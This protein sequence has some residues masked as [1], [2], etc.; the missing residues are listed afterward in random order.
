MRPA[1]LLAC[2]VLAAGV[3]LWLTGTYPGGAR[4]IVR[5]EG[6]QGLALT[7]DEERAPLPGAPADTAAPRSQPEGR[8]VIEEPVAP[9]EAEPESAA[10]AGP[11]PLLV[12]RVLRAD[13]EPCARAAIVAATGWA[14]VLP[15][16]LEDLG[17]VGNWVQ[18]V[19]VET[20]ADGRFEVREGLHL[21]GELVLHVA[22]PGHAP[23]R[24]DRPPPGAR[25]SSAPVD[26][27]DLRLRSGAV[28]R[29]RVVDR[30]GGAIAGARLQLAVVL[31]EQGFSVDFPA[32]GV[33]LAASGADGTFALDQLSPGPFTLLVEAP[34]RASARATEVAGQRPVDGLTVVLDAGR[35]IAGRVTGL[36]TRRAAQGS[37]SAEGSNAPA[38][39]AV[40]AA[41]PGLAPLRVEA[42]PGKP[43]GERVEGLERA[44]G[45]ARVALVADD[46]AFVV[47]GL[48][49]GLPYTLVVAQLNSEGKG[50]SRAREVTPKEAAPGTAGVELVWDAQ[51]RATLRVVDGATGAPIE[52]CT[53][54]WRSGPPPR[55]GRGDNLQYL[56]DGPRVRSAF[57]GGL[58]PLEGLP[59]GKQDLELAVRITAVGYKTKLAERLTLRGQIE[60]DLGEVRLESAPTVTVKV[61][62]QGDGGPVAGAKVYLAR[63]DYQWLDWYAQ[64]GQEV[65]GDEDVQSAVTDADGLAVLASLPGQRAKLTAAS[66]RYV[67]PEAK[68]HLLSAQGGD[69]LTVEVG[70]GGTLL[71]R[72]RRP[73]GA[74]AVGVKVICRK[75]ELG[76]RR[77]QART[78]E[79][80]TDETGTAR[81]LRLPAG[82]HE[83][84]VSTEQQAQRGQAAWR[85]GLVAVGGEVTVVL[86]TPASGTL[87]GLVLEAGQPLA[88]AS[89]TIG[90]EAESGGGED[91]GGFWGDDGRSGRQATSRADGSYTLGPIEAGEWWVTVRHESRAM[92]TRVPVRIVEGQNTLDVRLDVALL[93]GRVIDERDE[94]LAQLEA[95]VFAEK[96]NLQGGSQR[97]A[98]TE[99]PTGEVDSDWNWISLDQTRTD[100]EGAFR[101]RGLTTARP[102]K[103][104]V[105]GPYIE[106]LLLDLSDFAD[107]ELRDLGALRA[108]PAGVLRV[109]SAGGGNDRLRVRLVTASDDPAEDG[110][111]VRK[112]ADLRGSNGPRWSSVPLGRYRVEVVDSNG[113]PTGQR[114]EVEVR[115]RETA[116]VEV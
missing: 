12:G 110:R 58:V 116:T 8:A 38:D 21:G 29:G 63:A 74:P 85:P 71:A 39:G 19:R 59:A 83:A 11:P 45:G 23:L 88:R 60:T 3:L 100:A 103:L 93:E 13:G 6:A 26:Y 53:V 46:G 112:P 49:D 111:E 106:P 16:E 61:Q 76:S 31:G 102:L 55:P 34:G 50:W 82:L 42:R 84:A 72:V 27:G 52:R 30:A 1:S 28:V 96:V 20:D 17:Q 114:A 41:A 81:F 115:A 104:A 9:V 89:L 65:F 2:V 35:S 75:Q 90:T 22:A 40:G 54:Q 48:V 109:R 32:R 101:F 94:P 5:A 113:Q 68:D 33:T 43:G 56:M 80:V 70:E 86:D 67:A 37:S 97:I 36:D 47:D 44:V 18:R 105:N 64:S 73:N 98:L 91:W 7:Q 10:Q 107:A 69:V 79:E 57:P 14:Q 25:G 15:I 108:K 24:L 99:S 92:A 66:E 62:L 51:R 95:R 4:G 78:R 77:N 87:S